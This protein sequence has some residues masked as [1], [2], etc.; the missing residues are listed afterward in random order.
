MIHNIFS[1]HE[2]N[3]N[4]YSRH[5]IDSL[6]VGYDYQSIMQYGERAFAKWPW[7]KTI[8]PRMSGVSIGQRKKLSELDVKQAK[9]LYKCHVSFI[10]DSVERL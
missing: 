8:K 6:G 3:F 4:K 1:G 5:T 7:Q 2:H 9:L 10:N